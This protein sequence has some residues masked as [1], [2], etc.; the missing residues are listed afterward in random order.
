M[1]L[2][3]P[4][5]TRLQQA[6][7]AAAEAKL[8]A[9]PKEEVAK[10]HCM[11]AELKHHV[12]AALD[13]SLAE[14]AP[15]EVICQRFGAPLT[16]RHLA[17]LLP[18]RWLNDG[19]VTCYFRL[20]QERAGGKLWCPNTFFWPKLVADGAEAMQRWSKRAGVVV[21]NLRA[22]L[23]P[24]HTKGNH[25]SLGVVDINKH[26]IQY[27]DSLGYQPPNNLLPK[28]S[29]Y[30]L[31]EGRRAVPAAKFMDEPWELH[32]ANVPQQRNTSDCGVFACAFAER[33]AAGAKV[34]FSTDPCSV[35][36]LRRSLA[37]ALISGRL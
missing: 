3:A 24:M 33:F 8:S 34:A 31:A 4:E 27:M 30:L 16:R 12:D 20:L 22:I 11:D 9:H 35:A 2:A 5:P 23:V 19:V 21:P 18:G 32:C 15:D 29:E 1:P 7:P 36:S 26:C 28:L 17:C 14:L 37:T 6:L 10:P 25:W 13:E